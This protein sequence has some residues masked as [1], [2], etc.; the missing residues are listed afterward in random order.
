VRLYY[1]DEERALL[2]HRLG[3]DPEVSNADLAASFAAWVDNKPQPRGG[4]RLTPADLE[5]LRSATDSSPLD[6]RGPGNSDIAT[7]WLGQG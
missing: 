2:A 4:R 5:H 3:H 1:D 7:G 6:E